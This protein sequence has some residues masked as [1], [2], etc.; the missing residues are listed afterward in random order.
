[1]VWRQQWAPGGWRYDTPGCEDGP[2]VA[3]RLDYAVVHHTVN[4]NSYSANEA[5][6]LMRGIYWAHTN[7]NGWCDIAYNFIID[8]FGRIF[9]A[10]SGGTDQAIIGGH[11]AGFNTWATGISLL[12]QHQP[13]A[14]P[15]A[16]GVSAATRDALKRLL[17]WKLA[18]HGV[19]AGASIVR[20]SGGSTKYAEGVAVTL[21]TITAHRDIS[22]TSCPGDYSMDLLPALRKEVQAEV[23][24]SGPFTGI[25]WTAQP[26]VPKLL[27][28][29]TYG[30]LHPAGQ[31]R[32]AG[33]SDYWPGWSI[34]RGATGTSAGGW[35]LDGYGGI[36]RFGNA[37][38]PGGGGPYFP[39][40]DVARGIAEG[41]IPG[42]GYV[43]QGN[44]AVHP[45]GGATARVPAR[46]PGWLGKDIA[47]RPDGLGGYVLDAFGGVHPFGNAV[48]VAVTGYWPGWDITR[49]IAL[50]PDGV[51]GYVLDAYG[52]VHRF[53]NAPAVSVSRYESRDWARDLVLLA[54]GTGYVLDDAGVP[55]PVNGAP[56]VRPSLTWIGLNLSSRLL[57][58]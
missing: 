40:Q 5:F 54:D 18:L 31:G 24:R 53:G 33:P 11:S 58:G 15:P 41:P 13:G 4:T 20:V 43:L 44:G 30:G 48:P 34:V 25:R 51:G 39:G 1:M 35:V 38:A 23:S 52:G 22:S 14:S 9:E 36:H 47:T 8:R 17:V 46:W 28:V 55:W 21:P 26:S 3:S 50:R 37:P 2:Q 19:D 10:R 16:A 6:D 27:A 49:A 57:A 42:S 45:F 12:G 7:A 29:D 56:S 32:D